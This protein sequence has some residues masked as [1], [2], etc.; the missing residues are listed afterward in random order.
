MKHTTIETES[1]QKIQ[2]KL[3]V[4]DKQVILGFRFLNGFIWIVYTDFRIHKNLLFP[5][6]KIKTNTMHNV[7]S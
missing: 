2:S 3:T 1:V 7:A 6:S 5:Y 4:I